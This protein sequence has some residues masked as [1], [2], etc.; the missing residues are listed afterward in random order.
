VLCSP[1][2]PITPGL[3]S[4]H[5]RDG[6]LDCSARQG[7]VRPQ[8]DPAQPLHPD[9]LRVRLGLGIPRHACTP[10][11]GL[12]AL[13]PEAHHDGVHARV[14][15]LHLRWDLPLHGRRGGRPR[16]S[17][18]Q[19]QRQDQQAKQ[20]H[21]TRCALPVRVFTASSAARTVG[22]DPSPLP[23]RSARPPVPPHLYAVALPVVCS[24]RCACGCATAAAAAAGSAVAPPTG[25]GIFNC[26]K[27]AACKLKSCTACC[28]GGQPVRQHAAPPQGCDPPFVAPATR[29]YGGKIWR[30]E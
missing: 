17:A 9:H 14:L 27:G 29:G 24:P 23:R 1:V 13:R 2:P 4:A 12:P 26:H 30:G 3:D 11:V 15:Q 8:R 18:H 5:P 19:R 21:S 20:Q 10:Y 16:R 28:F 6:R 7:R 25:D 22:I